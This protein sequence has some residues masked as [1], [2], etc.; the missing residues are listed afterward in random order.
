MW[1]ADP[2]WGLTMSKERDN[3][4]LNVI[5]IL[6]GIGLFLLWLIFMIDLLIR[7]IGT[8]ETSD[9]SG[10]PFCL[11][12]VIIPIGI[13]FFGLYRQGIVGGPSKAARAK[14]P[15]TEIRTTTII[16]PN[17]CPRCG[18]PMRYLDDSQMWYCYGCDDNID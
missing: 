6:S 18:N 3:S 10:G 15:Y 5:F 16:S 8:V 1:Y 2:S 11:I 14:Q 13:I 7:P 12:T 9:N 4:G 17:T